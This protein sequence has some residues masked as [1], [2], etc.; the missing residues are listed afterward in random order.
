MRRIS[1]KDQVI[2]ALD[3]Q[4][5]AFAARH[6]NLARAIDRTVLVEHAVACIA[7]TPEY[8]DAMEEAVLAGATAAMLADIVGR[9]VR[10]WLSALI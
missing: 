10:R 5:P 7:D 2:K 8:R 9:F 6:P 3:V 4:W 1:L